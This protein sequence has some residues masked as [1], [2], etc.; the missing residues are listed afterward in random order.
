MP[1]LSNSVQRLTGNPT[2]SV[3]AEK[4]NR[5]MKFRGT[6]I[7]GVVGAISG[8]GADIRVSGYGFPGL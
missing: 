6:W 3:G 8:I 5:H 4:P 7:S 2:K 1:I